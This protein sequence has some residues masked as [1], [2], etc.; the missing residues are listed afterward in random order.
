MCWRAPYPTV[1][2]P[3]STS[4]TQYDGILCAAPILCA[5]CWNEMGKA[6]I[7]DNAHSAQNAKRC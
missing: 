4:S 3:S 6:V 7:V 5:L 1:I 2:V